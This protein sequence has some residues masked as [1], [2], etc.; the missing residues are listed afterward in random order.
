MTTSRSAAKAP[1]RDFIQA[2]KDAAFLFATPFISMAYMALFPFIAAKFVWQA[3]AGR[4][5][6]S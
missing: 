3:W 1:K 5:A 2:L 6:S 4:R